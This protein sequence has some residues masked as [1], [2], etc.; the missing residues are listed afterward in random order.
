MFGRTLNTFTS[1]N[2]PL[3]RNFDKFIVNNTL[4]SKNIYLSQTN[5][6]N[7]PLSYSTQAKK[8][9]TITEKRIDELKTPYQPTSPHL[10]IYKF[11]LPAVMSI[12]HRAT[13]ICLALGITGLA[14]VTLFAPHDAIHYIQLLHTQYPALVYPA[15]FAVALPLTY[16]FC[17]G[18][19]HII[20]D[21]TVKGLS[22][23]QIESSGKVLLAVVAVLSTIF[24]FVSFK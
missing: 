7:T 14:G 8:P 16:H 4:T 11:P 20:W 22:I 3:V 2:A 12:M 1:R 19:R 10:T 15:K 24:T 9:F 6:T 13:G 18:V 21:E 5:T 17:T 23:S